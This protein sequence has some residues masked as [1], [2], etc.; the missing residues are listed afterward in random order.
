VGK[1]QA[2]FKGGD[3]APHLD[4][5]VLPSDCLLALAAGSTVVPVAA[6]LRVCP[7][8]LGIDRLSMFPA[9]RGDSARWLI[10]HLVLEPDEQPLGSPR[11]A[12]AR[13]LRRR[14]GL[15]L[16]AGLFPD[17]AGLERELHALPPMMHE[18]PRARALQTC[19]SESFKC[20][21]RQ[22][23]ICSVPKAVLEC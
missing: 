8:E 10:A 15:G 11:T 4:C 12:L 1:R 13:K 16:G 9:A 7:R 23:F 20:R 22:R 3:G 6:S 19:V 2:P 5:A 17:S 14:W 21:T 18:D